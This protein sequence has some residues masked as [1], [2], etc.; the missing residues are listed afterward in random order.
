MGLYIHATINLK[1]I[2]DTDWEAAWLDS[3]DIF[4]RFP[5]PLSRHTIETKRGSKRHVYAQNLIL[6]KGKADECWYLEGD[7][8]S[9]QTGETF[10]LKRHLAAYKEQYRTHHGCF[11]SAVFKTDELEYPSSSNGVELWDSKTQG[12]PFHLAILAVGIMLENRF[13]D[14][15][16]IHGDIEETQVEVMLDWLEAVYSKP[17]QQ[18]I[19]FDADRLYEKLNAVYKNKKTL[20]ERF[21]VLYQGERTDECKALMRFMGK[22][23]AY[24]HYAK[25]L[26]YFNSLDQWGAQDIM[27]TILEVTEDVYEL[28]AFVETA[29]AQRPKKSK[30]FDWGDVLK[31]LCKDYVFVNPVQRESM[32]RLTKK[33]D[34]MDNINDVFG[35]LFMKMSGLP[36]ISPLY[37]PADELLEIFALRDPKN[38]KK[39]K[40]I[41]DEYEK[42][43][44]DMTKTVDETVQ[45]IDEALE[46]N[47]D[48]QEEIEEKEEKI[49]GYAP[50]E[51]YIV[52]QA[53]QQ[54]DRFGAYDQNV[55]AIRESLDKLM[56]KHGVFYDKKTAEAYLKEIYDYSFQ[57]GFGVSEKGWKTIDALTDLDILKY[58]FVLAS[59]NNN[60]MTFWRWR[61]HIFE[62]P[63]TW[64][65]FHGVNAK[66]AV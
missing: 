58:L 26:N 27:R 18:P 38:G 8:L 51:Q 11:K 55:P 44:T 45:A 12:Y 14:N 50:H 30:A 17:Y 57:A 36:H 3:L 52:R 40:D 10:V 7:L 6:D 43:L 56:K 32:K 1:G 48:F 62:T 23:G 61:K 54:Q 64:Q 49:D 41:L 34:D 33:S 15:C 63:A 66:P 31:L 22:E 20:F 53:I 19:C 24:N 25:D 29:I 28:V 37:V 21:T 13:P 42:K 60:E 65:Y 4:K 2:S 5:V 59:I 46:E 16:Y 35:R 9:M 39:Y 47:T